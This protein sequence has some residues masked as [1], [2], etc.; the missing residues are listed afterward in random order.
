MLTAASV[1]F[2]FYLTISKFKHT[3]SIK[4]S[5]HNFQ[6]TLANSDPFNLALC[7]IGLGFSTH[8]IAISKDCSL[9][10][11][12]KTHASIATVGGLGKLLLCEFAQRYIA[13]RLTLGLG[14]WTMTAVCIP[15]RYLGDIHSFRIA[16]H[17]YHAATNVPS[18][19][20]PNCPDR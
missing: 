20:H 17:G 18:Q 5:H 2:S 16:S 7:V 8:A 3:T 1:P 19:A 11:V 12:G 6:P 14:M 4:S 15:Q 10:S 13:V 9:V